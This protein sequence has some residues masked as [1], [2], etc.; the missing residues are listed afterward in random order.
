[1]EL[2][3]SCTSMLIVFV[4]L[5]E[6]ISTTD[7]TARRPK[8]VKPR[9]E[10]KTK[11]TRTM[12]AG[13][14]NTMQT[15]NSAEGAKWKFPSRPGVT[16]TTIF[17]KHFEKEKI[18]TTDISIKDTKN[19]NY[20]AVTLMDS[21]YSTNSYLTTNNSTGFF[22]QRDNSEHIWTIVGLTVIVTVVGS[23]LVI[24]F[25][26]YNKKL[27]CF[28]KK[29]QCDLERSSIAMLSE[30]INTPNEPV[31]KDNVLKVEIEKIN[32]PDTDT[33]EDEV[34]IHVSSA[35]TNSPV[36]VYEYTSKYSNIQPTD[37]RE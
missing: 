2:Q 33:T 24:V 5:T 23:V 34:D 27:L 9:N 36:C 3:F 37:A 7:I 20:S 4:V 25:L 19:L 35:S 32:T 21:A 18:S 11:T 8:Y 28:K 6:F 26:C 16:K 31:D 12:N 10:W 15:P 14:V 17:Q 13:N 29:A 22:H 1:M 30:N